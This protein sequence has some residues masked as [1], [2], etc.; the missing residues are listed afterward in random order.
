MMDEKE[1]LNARM[2]S[3]IDSRYALKVAKNNSKKAFIDEYHRA[4]GEFTEDIKGRIRDYKLAQR[5]ILYQSYP[6]LKVEVMP[7]DV[8]DTFLEIKKAS[9]DDFIKFYKSYI[10][11][12]EKGYNQDKIDNA[13]RDLKVAYHTYRMCNNSG[14]K[15]PQEFITASEM[16]N[17]YKILNPEE[18]TKQDNVIKIE[19]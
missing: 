8:L 14:W 2:Q 7:S 10:D 15:C 5:G 13:L 11:K 17:L 4:N 9:K 12:I 6:D 16:E 1:F 19:I 3:S 18:I